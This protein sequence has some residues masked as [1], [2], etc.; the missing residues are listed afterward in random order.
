MKKQNVPLK[1]QVVKAKIGLRMLFGYC[2]ALIKYHSYPKNSNEDKRRIGLVVTDAGPSVT[3]GDYFTAKELAAEL[4]NFGFN[5]VY[6]TRYSGDWY[7]RAG[8]CAVIISLLEIY[9]PLKIRKQGAKP[10]H[11]AWARNWFDRWAK[12][13]GITHYDYVMASSKSSADYL[14]K[15]LNREVMCFPIATSERRFYCEVGSKS[16]E[17]DVCF[18]GSYWY[19]EREIEGMLDPDRLQGYRFEVFGNN[20]QH[21]DKF[22]PSWRGFCHY[23]SL[24][25][26]Y[27]KTKIVLDD[28][29]SA[30]KSLGAVNSRVFDALAAGSLVITN[31]KL[32][33]TETFAGLLP[34]FST[35]D[36]LHELLN[37]Y[38]INEDARHEKVSQLQTFVLKHHTYQLRAA[39]LIE[40]LE[41]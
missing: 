24:P 33:A 21:S 41:M 22:L 2:S 11:V 8:E 5:V 40:L 4:E 10:I 7:F 31:G 20:W 9:N 16:F 26:I 27:S 32:G 23:E 6:L 29:N 14:Q 19:S 1:R 37:F 15:Q 30:T 36:E 38:L 12:A 39:R 35:S 28:A 17:R 34:S 18:T 13:P 3:F 25:E